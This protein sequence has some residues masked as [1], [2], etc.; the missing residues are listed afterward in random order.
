MSICSAMVGA[1]SIPI[2]YDEL[3]EAIKHEVTP[4][5]YLWLG[6]ALQARLM[7]DMTEPEWT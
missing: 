1:S 6:D 7:Q 4:G 2:D 3:P 5:E